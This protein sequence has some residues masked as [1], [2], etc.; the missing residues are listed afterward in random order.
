MLESTTIIVSFILLSQLDFISFFYHMDNIQNF[1]Q[2]MKNIELFNCSDWVFQ[3]K[4]YYLIFWE[5]TSDKE[6]VIDHPFM[7]KNKQ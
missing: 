2:K 4:G 5:Q 6:S 7:V 3:K 1:K